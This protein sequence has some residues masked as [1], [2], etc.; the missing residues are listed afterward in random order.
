MGPSG[1]GKST[2][3]HHLNNKYPNT[4]GFSISYTTR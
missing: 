1:A 4:F 3:I 2:M